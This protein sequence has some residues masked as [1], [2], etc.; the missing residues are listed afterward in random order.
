MMKRVFQIGMPLFLLFSAVCAQTLQTEPE[1]KLIFSG[2]AAALGV[3][4]VFDGILLEAG[5]NGSVKIP[6]KFKKSGYNF[7]KTDT[8]VLSSDWFDERA[9]QQTLAYYARLCRLVRQT[10]CRGLV[11]DTRSQNARLPFAVRPRGKYS[12]DA[13]RRQ[14]RNRGREWIKTAAENCPGIE[15]VFTLWLNGLKDVSP[16]DDMFLLADFASGVLEGAPNTVKIIDG[17]GQILSG[18]RMA[19]LREVAAAFYLNAP[20]VVPDIARNKLFRISGVA[21]PLALNYYAPDRISELR[22]DIQSG[23]ET[24]DS[25]VFLN[26][27]GR[28]WYK[29]YPHLQEVLFGGKDPVAAAVRFSAGENLLKN[30]NFTPGIQM[31]NPEPDTCHFGASYWFSWQ[32]NR[33][34]QGKILLEKEGAAF[35]G[36]AKGTV[37]QTL[38]NIRP[39]ELLLLTGR[40]KYQGNSLSA[41]F[42]CNFRDQKNK[43]M[44]YSQVKTSPGKPDSKGWRHAAVIVEVPAGMKYM[45]VNAGVSSGMFAPDEQDV[46]HI[47]DI[48]LRRIVYPWNK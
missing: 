17:N 34:K 38:Y 33:K 2:N 40:V 13:V 11:L 7:L 28:D 5:K 24:A 8:A 39:G 46:C 12:V 30:G 47:T 15:I 10:G 14:V 42:S 48:R 41:T 32:D 45:I 1:R 37:I 19:D 3:H 23:M 20:G 31:G 22:E 25:Y 27:S 26:C 6:D 43:F 29:K 4:H 9:W 21:V 16:A 35:R 18:R 36:T 44:R